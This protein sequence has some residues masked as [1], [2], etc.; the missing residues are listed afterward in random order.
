MKRIL[1][2]VYM[3]CIMAFN[4]KAQSFVRG[5]DISWCTEMESNGVHFYNA[6]GEQRDIFAL[7]KELGMTAIRL[8]VWVDPDGYGYGPW[9]DKADVL[10]KAK[11]AKNEG[12]DVMIDF[13]YSD[14]FA[15]PANQNVPNAWK[16]MT[17]DEVKQ[18]LANHTTEVLQ[19]LKE[20]G[21]TPKWV[22]VGNETNSGMVFPFGK[23][24]WAKTGTARF[25]DYVGLSNAGYDAVKSI[26]P[27][28]YVIIHLGGADKAQW[29]FPDFKAAGGKFDMIGLSHYPTASEWNSTSSDATY[30]NIN[31]AKYVQQAISQ[32]G[33]PVMICE[34]GFDVSKPNLGQKVMIDLFNRMKAISQCAGIFYWEPETNG[35]WKPA[36]YEKSDWNAYG[37]G[38]FTADGRPTK[39]L[40]AF[41]GKTV[42]DES[43]YPAYLNVY[44]KSGQNILAVLHPVEG[45]DG[46]YAGQLN[47]T[48]SWLNFKVVDSENNIWYGSDPSD[49][50]KL[51]SASDQWNL[52]IDGSKTGVYDI[53]VD[54]V[55]MNW[56][57]VYNETATAGI[58]AP[59]S[60]STS[61]AQWF[62]LSGREITAPVKGQLYIVKQ[63]TKV[64]KRIE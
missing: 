25:T 38:A 28:A 10:A 43:Q 30:S 21:V 11:R 31:A 8:R 46:I 56:T 34:T 19:A 36:Y 9:C 1:W 27:D 52:W 55:N 12:L 26:F 2:I 44:D 64:E 57:H 14:T 13:H 17:T 32:F 37:M 29:F 62:D 15:D 60:E 18:A 45:K 49:K 54:L 42:A 20:E 59:L 5:A 53:T 39:A 61:H 3:L 58:V 4:A 7:M 51:S 63:G 41:G 50:T 24:D 35:V 6:K 48:E 33:V 23:I 40:D 47:A 22:Q 16:D